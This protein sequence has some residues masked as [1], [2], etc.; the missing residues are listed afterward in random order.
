M[1][2]TLAPFESGNGTPV[3]LQIVHQVRGQVSAG[4]LLPGQ[5]VPTIRALAEQLTL[6]PNTVARAYRELERAGVFA[7]RRGAGTVVAERA[8]ERA[9]ME[10]RQELVG[11]VERLVGEAR[12]VGLELDELVGLVRQCWT[13]NQP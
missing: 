6:N 1:T 10:C 11:R 7:T 13:E 2:I 9:R 12:Q 4:R 8:V 5:E 3:Y